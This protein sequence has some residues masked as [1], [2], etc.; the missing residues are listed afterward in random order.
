V[1][2]NRPAL[3]GLAI[4]RSDTAYPDDR[5]TWSVS[6]GDDGTFHFHAVPP[7]ASSPSQ[8][9]GFAS[10]YRFGSDALNNAVAQY[11]MHASMPTPMYGR[12][13]DIYA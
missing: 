1:L 6:V 5:F 8:N 12:S 10:T 11:Q 4:T 13:V 9:G 2:A 7:M 3:A